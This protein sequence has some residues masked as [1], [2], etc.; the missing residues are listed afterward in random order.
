MQVSMIG[1]GHVG[2]V[3]GLCL[4]E[5]GHRVV[6]VDIDGPKVA[7][8][9]RGLCPIHEKGVQELLHKHLNRSFHVTMD[10]DRAVKESEIII[11][12]VDTPCRD[13]RIDL[14]SLQAVCCQIGDVLKSRNGFR[15]VAVRSTVVPGTTENVVRPALES[16]SSKRAGVEFTLTVNPEFLREGSAVHDFLNPDRIIMGAFDERGLEVLE[17][18]YRPFRNTERIRTSPRTAEM[19]KYASSGLLATLISFSNEMSNLCES[20]GGIDAREVMA[21]VCLDRRWSPVLDD[22]SRLVPP[23]TEYLEAGCGFGGSCLPK[24]VK[25]LISHGRESGCRMRLLEAV[26]FVNERQPQRMI[27]VLEN[28]FPR[29]EELT[30]AVL[31][32]SFK[33]GTDDVRESP[34]V[35]IILELLRRGATVN[36]YDPVAAQSARRLLGDRGIVYCE[37]IEAA[38]DRVHAVML[39]TRWDEFTRL[40]DLLANREVQPLVIDGRRMISRDS[41]LRYE[42][43]GLGRA[44]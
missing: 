7:G 16:R 13:G 10:L 23:I 43:T 32:L 41:V 4:A 39:V 33:P 34:A 21:G 31:G 36:A 1:A 6:C 24:D 15:T 18:L 22:G 29:V 17:R 3:S 37:T 35:T 2:L 14:R 25:A 8:L 40:P 44:E 5:L 42:G 27:R 26:L 19:I 30:I 20:L 12:A 11:I 9:N 38:L 28:H